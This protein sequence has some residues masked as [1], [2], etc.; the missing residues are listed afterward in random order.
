G[1]INNALFE[2]A[3]TCNF[4]GRSLRTIEEEDFER[5]LTNIKILDE[6]EVCNYDVNKVLPSY[7]T[8]LGQVDTTAP[9]VLYSLY[10]YL[11]S[12]NLTNASDES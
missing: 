5:D 10:Y 9:E 1:L 2:K 8:K 6:I 12:S 4:S 3:K 11:Q 7:L